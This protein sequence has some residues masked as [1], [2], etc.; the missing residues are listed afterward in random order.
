MAVVNWVAVVAVTATQTEIMA[1]AD[2]IVPPAARITM[3]VG[4]TTTAALIPNSA[5]AMVPLAVTLDA[6][7]FPIP[8]GVAI[9][10][11]NFPSFSE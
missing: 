6:A 7:M 8:A 3:V 11:V 4:A 10:V 5:N 9:T 1:A 2:T